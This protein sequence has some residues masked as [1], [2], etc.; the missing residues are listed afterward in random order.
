MVR[1]GT[2]QNLWLGWGGGQ[3]LVPP[4]FITKETLSSYSL[5]KNIKSKFLFNILT[6]RAIRAQ[7][8]SLKQSLKHKH[9]KS[10]KI[11]LMYLMWHG[12][13]DEW[14]FTMF[15]SC[16]VGAELL[17]SELSV[18]YSLSS[19]MSSGQYKYRM[20]PFFHF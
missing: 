8:F 1:L 7:L 2:V 18:I 19:V 4:S 17:P 5:G 12:E 13:G 6:V 3:K 15:T 10:N 16:I 9:G 14:W 11:V 20:S